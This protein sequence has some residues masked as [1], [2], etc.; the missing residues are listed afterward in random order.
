MRHSSQLKVNNV[1]YGTSGSFYKRVGKITKIN[2]SKPAVEDASGRQSNYWK[3][4]MLRIGTVD[5]RF[6]YCSVCKRPGEFEEPCRH[7]GTRGNVCRGVIQGNYDWKLRNQAPEASALS[8]GDR[9]RSVVM[10][11]A[12][13]LGEALFLLGITEI[14]NDI[15]NEVRAGLIGSARARRG[16]RLDNRL[17]R[18]SDDVSDSD[19]D[20]VTTLSVEEA[21]RILLTE[22]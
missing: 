1:I 2:P 14:S 22:S 16:L 11:L 18:A 4:N 3:S 12:K 13:H 21:S 15:I 9:R 19:D 8:E 6:G 10:L 5:S 17:P 7:S 20:L